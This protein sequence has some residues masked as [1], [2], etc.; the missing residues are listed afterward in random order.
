MSSD[1]NILGL[2]RKA[3][4]LSMGHDACKDSVRGKKACVCLISKESSDRVFNEFTNLCGQYGVPIFKIDLTIEQINRIT[5]Y[6]AGILTIN[7]PGFAGAVMKSINKTTFAEV[8][9]YDK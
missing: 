2:C 1:L 9:A 7:D 3:N 4:K 8:E 6:K 5:G